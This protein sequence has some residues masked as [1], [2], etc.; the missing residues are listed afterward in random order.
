MMTAEAVRE[1]DI[2]CHPGIMTTILSGWLCGRPTAG[3]RCMDSKVVSKEIRGRVWPVLK[4]NGFARFTTRSAWRYSASTIDVLNFQSFNSY[5][6]S[7]MRVTPFSFAVNLGSFL[8][9]VPPELPPEPTDGHLTPSEPE[10]HFR[11]SLAPTIKQAREAPRGV[12]S[13][14]KKG[15]NLAGCIEDVVQQLPQAMAWFGR[16]A[17]KREVLRILRE[18]GEDMT[19]L[20]GFGRNPSP[21]RSRLTGY[22]ALELKCHDLAVE[23]LGEAAASDLFADLPSKRNGAVARNPQFKR[24]QHDEG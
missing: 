3:A 2:L 19:A 24:S 7:V 12:W 15:K 4:E 23:K 22:V 11:G 18:D 8:T 17:D 16:L 21:L 5:H 20:W 6:A 9:Y 10:C 14:E 1:R 13:V